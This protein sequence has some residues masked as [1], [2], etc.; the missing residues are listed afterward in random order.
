VAASS[1]TPSK[2]RTGSGD[3]AS[4][5]VVSPL[6][7]RELR[8]QGRQTMAKLL[9]AG[10]QVLTERGYHAARVDDVVRM[11]DVSHGTFYLYFASKEDLF[12]AL[13]VQCADEMKML[14]ASLGPVGPD[15][16]GQAE[17]RRWLGEFIGCY[18]TF[19]VVIRA[20]MEDQIT[21]REL[22]RLGVRTFGAISSSLVTRIDEARPGRAH[23]TEL[24]AAALL[25]LIERFTYFLTSRNLGFDDDET[26]ST[27]AVVIH[28]AFFAPSPATAGR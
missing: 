21:S 10:M 19:G 4:T 25:A 9:D 26:I 11:A 5:A 23:Q 24:E 12:R 1:P 28:R 6:D 14:A 27:L 17:L 2:R 20:W 15:A 7:G 8:T 22:S 16:E 3:G 18:R 13:A